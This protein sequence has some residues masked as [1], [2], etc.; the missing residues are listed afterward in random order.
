[1]GKQPRS[2]FNKVNGAKLSEHP[3]IFLWLICVCEMFVVVGDLLNY[4]L[5]VAAV[6]LQDCVQ[7]STIFSVKGSIINGLH[8][9]VS[10]EV[11]MFTDDTVIS[12]KNSENEIYNAHM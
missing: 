7:G 8:S 12:F 9:K 10:S 1:M 11:Q 2:T 5:H 3:C 6:I 4:P